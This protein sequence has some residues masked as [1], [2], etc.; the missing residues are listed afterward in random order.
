MVIITVKQLAGKDCL[1]P[2]IKMLLL[3]FFLWYTWC[4]KEKTKK[5]WIILI[6]ILIG[7]AV[8]A[9]ITALCVVYQRLTSSG[10][11]FK[12]Y[13]KSLS[14]YNNTPVLVFK[15]TDFYKYLIRGVKDPDSP[16][17]DT[18]Q[19]YLVKGTADFG[20]D[21]SQVSIDES[22]TNY[23]T[24]SITADFKSSSYFPVFAD[25][26]IA[27]D[28]ITEVET[29]LPRPYT[30]EEAEEKA[31]T[32]G[33]VGSGLGALLGGSAFSLFAFEPVSKIT[34]TAAGSVIGAAA[35]GI[36]SYLLTK[37]FLMNYKGSDKAAAER[38][39]LLN[40]A[41]PLI[42]LELLGNSSGVSDEKSLREWEK[43][44]IHGFET[45]IRNAVISFFKQFGWKHITV[46]ISYPS[47]FDG[48]ETSF[49]T[50]GFLNDQINDG[51]AE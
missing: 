15:Q 38:E 40:S 50:D 22:K 14:D 47:V 31:L 34:G 27:E 28:D 30:E 39:N 11:A 16:H 5:T 1:I 48:M 4:V 12:T 32:A 36:T 23:L 51:E 7:I 37:N 35:G 43:S 10:D 41:K 6:N 3:D 21:L 20:F 2:G 24:R 29:I 26:T 25:I 17:S 19:V 45:D 8:L 42:A 44:L 13:V 46:N 33:I 18:L 49:S 9:G